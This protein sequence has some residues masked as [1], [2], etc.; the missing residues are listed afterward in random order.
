MAG[1]LMLFGFVTVPIALV[2]AVVALVAFRGTVWRIAASLPLVLVASYFAA[3]LI[4]AW[5]RDPTSHNLFPFELG[6]YFW[7]VFPYMAA[8]ISVY[9]MRRRQ[10][11]RSV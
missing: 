10:R 5:M 7:P 4:P 3:V 11:L 6:M 9:L 8:L 1:L 2:G